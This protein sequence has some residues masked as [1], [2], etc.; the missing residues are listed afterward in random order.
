L[1]TF[2][3][4]DLTSNCY[5]ANTCRQSIKNSNF[6]CKLLTILLHTFESILE[7]ITTW[8]TVCLLSNPAIAALWSYHFDSHSVKWYF[9]V[10]CTRCRY[11][12]L[13][14]F[15]PPEVPWNIR[16]TSI[17]YS[18]LDIFLQERFLRFL[19]LLLPP[20]STSGIHVLYPA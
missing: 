16:L 18:V 6:F 10:F 9:V 11:V 3:C 20:C 15:T 8:W 7:F 4:I 13:S 1:S 2:L 14:A 17:Y 5:K 12:V 19:D